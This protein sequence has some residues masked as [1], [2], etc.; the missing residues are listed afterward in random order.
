MAD[1]TKAIMDQMA[2]DLMARAEAEFMASRKPSAIELPRG[3]Q[4]F[5][6]MIRDAVSEGPHLKFGTKDLGN[7]STHV[8]RSVHDDQL[9]H[10]G[11]LRSFSRSLVG[12]MRERLAE[13]HRPGDGLVY[14]S[15]R[16]AEGGYVVDA[17]FRHRKTAI[18]RL[19]EAIDAGE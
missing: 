2:A 17:R 8:E 16:E 5:D 13:V 10:V 14:F 6:A 7:A 19:K 1:M 18:E 4:D 15:T 3:S 9:R 11:D 12:E